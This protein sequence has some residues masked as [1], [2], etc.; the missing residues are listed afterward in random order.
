MVDGVENPYRADM[1]ASPLFFGREQLIGELVGAARSGRNAVRAVMGGRGMG[2]SSLA[3]RLRDRLEDHANVVVTQGA[4]QEASLDVGRALGIDL[5][6]GSPVKDLVE[7]AMTDPRGRVVLVFDEIERVVESPGGNLFLDNLRK[8]Y[9]GSRGKLSLIVLGGTAIR[10]LLEDKASPFLRVMGAGVHTLKGL[11][12]DETA[13]LLRAPLGL[14]IHEDVVDALWAETAGHPWLLQMFMEYAV[15]AA[16]SL[17]DVVKCIPAAVRRAESRLQDAGFRP[18]WA[19]FRVRGQEVYRRIVRFSSG[20]PKDRW[21][22]SFGNDPEPWLQVLAS[23]G[24]VSLDDDSV[25]A[26]GMLFQRWVERNFPSAEPALLEQDRLDEWLTSARADAFERLLVRALSTWARAMIE[27]PA[28]TLKQDADRREGNN[29]LSP[30]AFFQMHA[31]VALLQHEQE[32]TAEAEAISAGRANR[33]DIKVR[34]RR[35]NARRACVEVKIF[36]RNDEGVV[37]QV[38]GYAMPED[39]FAIVVSVDRC[40]RSL[41]PAYE[42]RCLRAPH[43]TKHEPP[44]GVLRPAFY[45]LHPRDGL[46]PLRIWHVLIQLTA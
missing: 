24:I 45:T 5:S 46:A 29:G 4:V 43:P 19:N 20:I 15:E 12:R 13:S 41:R 25:I 17:D 11:E 34:S 1:V 26:R 10:D 8:A 36:G 40:Q 21:V 18:W 27:F 16:A 6:A 30:E 23:T 37:D 42:E 22:A 35:D 33:S 14:D 3:G 44:E 9:E 2:K 7:A 32:L 39:T 28:A 31:I 38:L